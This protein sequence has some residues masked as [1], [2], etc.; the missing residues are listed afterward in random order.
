MRDPHADPVTDLLLIRHTTH[1]E[2]LATSNC[3]KKVFQRARDASLRAA[4]GLLHFVFKPSKTNKVFFFL[5]GPRRGEGG[6]FVRPCA[7][8]KYFSWLR[9]GRL[10]AGSTFFFSCCSRTAVRLCTRAEKM[11]Y[12]VVGMTNPAPRIFIFVVPDVHVR[13]QQQRKGITEAQREREGAGQAVEGVWQARVYLC[14]GVADVPSGIGDIHC[15]AVI[16]PL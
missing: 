16:M 2:R 7:A 4:C 3:A 1:H 6:Y 13:L 12:Q 8:G 14:A 10:T 11:L 5:L 9:A 15:P